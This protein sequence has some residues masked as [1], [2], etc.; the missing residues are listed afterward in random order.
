MPLVAMKL[1]TGRRVDIRD[2]ENVRIE[3]DCSDLVCPMDD[4]RIPM[5][6]VNR[7]LFVPHFR[8][9]SACTTAY[10]SS[11]DGHAGGESAF[12][13]AGKRHIAED[14]LAYLERAGVNDAR[15]DFEVPIPEIKRIAD[16][17]ITLPWGDKAVYECQ[18]AKIS[19]DDLE[20]RTRDYAK[21]GLPCVWY[22]GRS[23]DTPDNRDWCTNRIGG[24]HILSFDVT[25]TIRPTGGSVGSVAKAAAR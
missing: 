10:R 17:V 1:S 13:L 5:S 8:H 9:R 6:P 19:V 15:A 11:Y 14:V 12:H 22:L 24:F 21:A 25:S 3:V 2:Y 23:A 4:C 7:N 16:V 20:E 18:L